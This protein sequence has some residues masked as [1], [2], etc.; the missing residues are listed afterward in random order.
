M[1]QN[2]PLT[3]NEARARMI[4]E[5]TEGIA[6]QGLAI[7]AS[8]V[9]ADGLDRG[10]WDTHL[11]F[12][13]CLCVQ[14]SPDNPCRCTGPIVWI[15]RAEIVQSSPSSRCSADG[16]E[17]EQI[18]VQ[19]RTELIVDAASR[20]PVEQFLAERG[21]HKHTGSSE[22]ELRDFVTIPDC[23]NSNTRIKSVELLY[24]EGKMQL[25][26]RDKNNSNVSTLSIDLTT[27][28]ENEIGFV[29]DSDER[30][31]GVG[32]LDVLS[33]K[34]ERIT[35]TINGADFSIYFHGKQ[36]YVTHEKI[37]CFSAKKLMLL[38][39]WAETIGIV[40]DHLNVSMNLTIDQPEQQAR[41]TCARL[42]FA[43]IGL[44]V[45]CG[46]SLGIWREGCSSSRG[47]WLFWRFCRSQR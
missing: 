43:S 45:A 26:G 22:C 24:S 1:S 39:E 42:F 12:L 14:D 15:P 27:G 6:L 21:A 13:W 38:I 41:R 31:R 37:P 30:V 11:P 17:I 18:I 2:D 8:T 16:R 35:G 28:C 32:V 46:A 29:I 40:N 7:H 23:C 44:G 36:E 5:E 20:I 33:D 25:V 34:E 19:R 10:P 47:A 9:Q 4:E 3:M